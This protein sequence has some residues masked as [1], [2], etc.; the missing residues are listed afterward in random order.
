MGLFKN[1]LNLASNGTLDI[2]TPLSNHILHLLVNLSL[3]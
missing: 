3:I 1:P 2:S